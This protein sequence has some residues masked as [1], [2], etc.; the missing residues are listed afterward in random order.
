M[1]IE[2]R[3]AS[4]PGSLYNG[5]SRISDDDGDSLGFKALQLNIYLSPMGESEAAGN[6]FRILSVFR[7]KAF[8]GSRETRGGLGT[9][10]TMLK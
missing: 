9:I 2:R 7:R 5:M 1:Y 8:L 3:S 4:N 10:W 6:V